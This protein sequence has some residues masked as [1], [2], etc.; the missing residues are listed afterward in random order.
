NE[1]VVHL[2]D[3]LHPAVLRLIAITL[4]AGAKAELPVSVCGEMAGNPA[5]TLLLLGMGLRHFSM[6][7]ARILE[8][9]QQILRADLNELVP[10]VQ[11]ILKL[12]DPTRIREAVEKLA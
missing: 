1:A 9:K 8:I 5:Y 3:P 4:Q 11:R 12:E 6:H 10:K 7:P 2:Y